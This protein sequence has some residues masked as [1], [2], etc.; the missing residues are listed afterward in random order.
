MLLPGFAHRADAG[1]G[2]KLLSAVPAFLRPGLQALIPL[3]RR[4][5]LFSALLSIL[6]PGTTAGQGTAR[7][8]GP[9]KWVGAAMLGFKVLGFWRRFRSARASKK[10]RR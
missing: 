8:G 7:S 1:S 4:H 2:E 9:A 6:V 3:L 5:P 10:T